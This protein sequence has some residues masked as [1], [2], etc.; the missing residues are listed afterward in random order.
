MKET[1]TD[2]ELLSENQF[3]T[4][5]DNWIPFN[6][7]GKRVCFGFLRFDGLDGLA[8]ASNMSGGWTKRVRC[9]MRAKSLQQISAKPTPRVVHRH[10][11]A[12]IA[13]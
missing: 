12:S 2:K 8:N 11:P 1:N 5:E 3:L 9:S 6:L 7:S 10:R 13:Q 4:L